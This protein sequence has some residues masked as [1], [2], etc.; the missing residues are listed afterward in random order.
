M[1]FEVMVAVAHT[2][3]D[4]FMSALQASNDLLAGTGREVAVF[5]AREG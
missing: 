1:A 4:D 3:A 2:G 5:D